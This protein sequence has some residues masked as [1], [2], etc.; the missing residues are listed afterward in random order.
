M[1]WRELWRLHINSANSSATLNLH[2][3]FDV[4]TAL[5]SANT[6]ELTCSNTNVAGWTGSNAG[7]IE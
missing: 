1:K 5:R 2:L 4:A 7:A 3:G 6:I